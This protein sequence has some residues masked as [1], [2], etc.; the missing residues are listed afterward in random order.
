MM[1]NATT[2]PTTS[3]TTTPLSFFRPSVCLFSVS[4]GLN[5]TLHNATAADTWLRQMGAAAATNNVTVQYCMLWPRFALQSLLLPSVTQARAS[6]DYAP[7]NDQWRIGM[8]SLFL[9]ALGLRPTKDSFFSNNTF[10]AT[11]GKMKGA[12]GRD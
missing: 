11:S 8:V 9:D 5:L 4:V 12:R 2:T 10:S 1:L 7:G 6:G 3:T